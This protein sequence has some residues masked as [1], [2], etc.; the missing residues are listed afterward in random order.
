MKYSDIV[1]QIKESPILLIGIGNELQIKE[2]LIG[3]ESFTIEYARKVY[4]MIKKEEQEQLRDYTEAYGVIKK[5]TAGKDYFIVTTNTD[6]MLESMGFDADRIVSP[7]GS[8]FRMQCEEQDH[9]VW[10]IKEMLL[11]QNEI[12]CPVCQKAG[13]INVI[14]N[15][16][17]NESGYMKQWEIYTR[18]L[19]RTI[20]R[21]IMLLELGEGF[22][23]PTVIRWP[24]EKIAYINQKS[25]FVRVNRTYPQLAE[26]MKERACSV[27]EDSISFLRQISELLNK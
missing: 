27:K 10:D 5:M 26:E 8:I 24:F 7:C 22:E 23:T 25:L 9:G 14:K 3:A 15:K 13:K 4:Q 21:K 18:W 20:N 16:P 6:G 1:N 12:K 19:Q 2:T 11:R 17:Y